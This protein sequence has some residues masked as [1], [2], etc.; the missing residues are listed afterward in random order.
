METPNFMK[1]HTFFSQFLKKVA[2]HNLKDNHH[3]SLVPSFSL[4]TNAITIYLLTYWDLNLSVA[5]VYLSLFSAPTCVSVCFL[6]SHLEAMRGNSRQCRPRRA[7]PMSCETTP[8]SISSP[9]PHHPHTV[10]PLANEW[11]PNCLI[12]GV[13]LSVY[14]LCIWG[15][16]TSSV[17]LLPPLLLLSPLVILC[18][19]PQSSFLHST[20]TTYFV[21]ESVFPLSISRGRQL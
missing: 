4:F 17:T 14:S 8:F 7:S 11:W 9:L 13:S 20:C 3:L 10:I 16:A 2:D 18:K 19:Y 12:S 1:E 15:G 5:S 6:R 21:S